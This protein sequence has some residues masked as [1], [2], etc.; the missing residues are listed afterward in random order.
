MSF[1]L[2]K[3]DIEGRW[4]LSKKELDLIIASINDRLQLSNWSNCFAE[5]IQNY[6]NDVGKAWFSQVN[7]SL[8]S[9]SQQSWRPKWATARLQVVVDLHPDHTVN[10][11]LGTDHAYLPVLLA[12]T[13]K[14]PLAFGVD[15]AQSP[16]IN[17]E[18][19]IKETSML[20][21]ISLVNG[22]GILPFLDERIDDRTYLPLSSENYEQWL[23][24]KSSGLVTVTICGVGGYLAAELISNLP[25]WVSTVIVQANDHPEA[26]DRI[27]SDSQQRWSLN[28]FSLTIERNRLFV[29]KLAQREQK[30]LRYDPKNDRLWR[31]F[32]LS[33]SVRKLSL[34]PSNHESLLRKQ[35]K[36]DRAVK[37]FF[38]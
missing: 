23:E 9:Q 28:Q 6:I 5:R 3:R 33:R 34:T 22:D 37:D 16:L 31:W 27:L 35:Q 19:V 21:C 2:E 20:G 11:D 8:R 12:Q 32:K 36:L 1:R 13:K 7:G 14:V 24:M 29:T 17:A 15:I 10:I 25:I 26:V 30:S 4:D 18:K 38:L